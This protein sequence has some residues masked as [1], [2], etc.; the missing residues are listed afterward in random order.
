M[1]L[2][3]D[4]YRTEITAQTAALAAEIQTADLTA[5]VPS[6]PD[7]NLH[8]LLHHIG[9][10]HRWAAEVV[11]T[12][13]TDPLPDNALRV[14][15]AEITKSPADLATWLR[16]GADALTE[17]LGSTSPDTP[18]WSPVPRDPTASFYARRFTHE[19][20]MHRVDAAQAVRQSTA[21]LPV[22]AGV[23]EDAVDEYFDL[24]TLPEMFDFFPARRELL[25]PGRTLLFRTPDTAP[26]L[27]DLSG[28]TMTYSRPT[29]ATETTATIEGSLFSLLLALYH[30]PPATPVVSSGDAGVLSLWDKHSTFG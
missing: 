3:Y 1:P 5:R 19:T 17:A 21:D 26:W 13:A 15:P 22:P 8:Q 20:L 2:R 24:A 23:L 30:R 28:T 12:R 27:L 11:R 6:C 25:A 29:E 18:V 4:R 9:E 14:L 7:W 16:E 10:G